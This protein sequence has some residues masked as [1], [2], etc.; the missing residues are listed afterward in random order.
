MGSLCIR[1]VRGKKSLMT[2]SNNGICV[3]RKRIVE[4]KVGIGI[5]LLVGI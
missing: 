2:F 3:Y 4:V 5:D 1:F